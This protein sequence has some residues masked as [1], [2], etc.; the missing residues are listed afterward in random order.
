MNV[1]VAEIKVVSMSCYKAQWKIFPDDIT[2]VEGQPYVKL[3]AETWRLQ[4]MVCE[5]ND[6]YN[7]DGDT[8]L[9]RCSLA[10]SIGLN[11]MMQMRAAAE[12]QR[13]APSSTSCVF[14]PIPLKKK[15]KGKT[16]L[17]LGQQ[18][19]QQVPCCAQRSECREG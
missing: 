13:G 9:K 8:K 2:Y 14:E 19:G 16:R 11:T 12:T 3:R 10:S 17:E 7:I 1:Q 4:Q 5:Q 18:R 15:R 6:M